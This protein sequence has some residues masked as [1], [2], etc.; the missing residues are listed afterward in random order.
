MVSSNMKTITPSHILAFV[1]GCTIILL[2]SLITFLCCMRRYHFR[3]QK[4][5]KEDI[6]EKRTSSDTTATDR[7]LYGHF[8]R[9]ITQYYMNQIAQFTN[10][11]TPMQ[12]IDETGHLEEQTNVSPV[13]YQ[14]E[15][16][17]QQYYVSFAYEPVLNDEI[18]LN[19]GDVVT[20][21]KVYDDGWARGYNANTNQYGML[22]IGCL[23]PLENKKQWLRRPRRQNTIA[24]GEHALS[25]TSDKDTTLVHQESSM[26]YSFG[27]ILSVDQTP[28]RKSSCH[29][30]AGSTWQRRPKSRSSYLLDH[31][32]KTDTD[33]IQA[34]SLTL[35]SDQ[36]GR[37]IKHSA[38]ADTEHT[39]V[40]KSS[41][42]DLSQ[43]WM[44]EPPPSSDDGK[45][46]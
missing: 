32:G 37:S 4:R 33:M 46:V 40:D 14:S 3:F 6:S 1:L 45:Y 36:L 8:S 2:I 22:P 28:K 38:T 26:G 23:K 42:Q 16:C 35:Q 5:T 7:G 41:Q 39:L 25:E 15:L 19:L 12:P 24:S 31:H 21:Y 27:S 18:Q 34:S 17:H 29:H 20:I 44:F 13:D 10:K 43:G 11:T 30:A 9:S